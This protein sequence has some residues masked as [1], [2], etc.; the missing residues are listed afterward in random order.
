MGFLGELSKEAQVC[1]Q[2]GAGWRGGRR[3]DLGLLGPKGL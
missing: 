3:A 1:A 2:D